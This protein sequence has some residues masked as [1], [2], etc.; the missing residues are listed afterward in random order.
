MC[1]Q[2]QSRRCC[3]F[4]LS[5]NAFFAFPLARPCGGVLKAFK[6]HTLIAMHTEKLSKTRMELQRS[7]PLGDWISFLLKLGEVST[8]VVGTGVWVG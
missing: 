1:S 6:I 5:I 2:R 3:R 4:N 8:E 7:K